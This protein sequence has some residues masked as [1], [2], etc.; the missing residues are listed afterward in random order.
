MPSGH[1][2][3]KGILCWL[4]LKGEPETPKKEKKLAPLGNW[5]LVL[6]VT[7]PIFSPLFFVSS[8]VGHRKT[9]P[10]SYVDISPRN[11]QRQD[12]RPGD[13]GLSLLWGQLG[14]QNRGKPHR[15]SRPLISRPRSSGRAFSHPLGTSAP[16]SPA[17]DADLS[18]LHPFPRGRR[19]GGEVEWHPACRVLVRK[20][21]MRGVA[22]SWIL[23][24][25][26]L[27]EIR[28]CVQIDARNQ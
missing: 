28:R 7:A 17:S 8:E 26:N 15:R 6:P 19:R 1:G 20:S 22:V 11:S 23:S 24:Q 27:N 18:A 5:A 4:T 21:P 16:A 13:P 9:S 25:E 10:V 14:R 12:P 3:N 2:K